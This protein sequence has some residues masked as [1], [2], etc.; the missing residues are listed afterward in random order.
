MEPNAPFIA[1]HFGAWRWAAVK[2]LIN[3][4]EKQALKLPQI[5]VG[6]D[7]RFDDFVEA[8]K[9]AKLVIWLV[10]LVQAIK[11][12]AKKTVHSKVSWAGGKRLERVTFTPSQHF[13]YTM[14]LLYCKTKRGR[15]DPDFGKFL[16]DAGG[17]LWA[18]CEKCNQQVARIPG[19]RGS[20]RERQEG[21]LQP[22]DPPPHGPRPFSKKLF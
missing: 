20:D 16:Q 13:N 19:P 9:V 1:L 3:E 18:R 22:S 5:H 12:F 2:H 17:R 11:L 21:P 14:P 7:F 15:F 6:K 8:G 10:Q 4:A